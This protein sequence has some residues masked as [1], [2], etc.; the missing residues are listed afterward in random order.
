MPTIRVSARAL[1]LLACVLLPVVSQAA[2]LRFTFEGIWAAAE[3]T[4]DPADPLTPLIGTAFSGRIEIPLDGN[5][6]D[7]A[8][9]RGHYVFTP[10]EAV[11]EL[12]LA[13]DDFDFA[14]PG[15]IDVE[16]FDDATPAQL[17][18]CCAGD[19]GPPFHDQLSISV[20]VGDYGV[21]F[22]AGLRGGSPPTV[23]SSD[24]IPTATEIL[25]TTAFSLYFWPMVVADPN[26]TALIATDPLPALQ[27][28]GSLPDTM[29]VT[30][31]TVPLSDSFGYLLLALIVSGGALMRGRGVG[32]VGP[33]PA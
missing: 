1:V 18:G 10:G 19:D 9:H 6:L 31:T 15:V 25:N 11:F 29:N 14:T 16:V 26:P 4:T 7:P 22:Q 32:Y 8:S 21:I 13:G 27:P 28:P 3:G 20:A 2:Y 12:D 30:L 23:F 5:D 24:R 33:R 17:F